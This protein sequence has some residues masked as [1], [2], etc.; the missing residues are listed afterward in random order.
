MLSF[1]FYQLIKH[2]EAFRKAQLEV[3]EVIGDGAIKVEHLS[4]LPYLN[5]VLRETLRVNA[6]IPAIAV[7][8]K[9]DDVIGGKYAVKKGEPVVCLLAKCHLD[10]LVYGEDASEFKPDRMLDENFEKLNKEFP[11]CWKPFGNGMRACIGRQFAWQE[12]LLVLAIL[13]QNFNFTFDDPSYQLSIKQNLTI[14]PLGFLM[15]ASPRQGMS[16]TAMEERLMSGSEPAKKKEAQRE[17]KA[18]TEQP[19]SRGKPMAI[20]YGSNTGTCEALAQRLANDAPSHGYHATVVDAMDSVNQSLSHDHPI[21]LLTASYEGQP[22]DNA[23]HFVTW[24]ESLNKESP[25]LNGVSYAVFGCGHHDWASTFHRIPKLVDQKM[26]E[27]GATRIAALGLADVARGDMFSDFDTWEADVFWPAMAEKYGAS[28]ATA[29]GAH[30]SIEVQVS[31]PRCSTLRQDVQEAL[32]VATK[33]LTAPGVPEK[34]HIEIQLPS[35]VTYRSGD[36]MAVL[37]LNSTDIVHRAMRRFKLAWDSHLTITSPGPTLLPTGHSIP[38]SDVFGAYVE[39]SQPATKR[40]LQALVALAKDEETQK[41]LEKLAGDDFET[42][43]SAKRVSLLDLLEH[44]PLLA[45]PMPN[46]LAMLPPM[47]VRQYSISS[48]PLWNP[49]HA[50][51]TF[52]ILDAPSFSDPEGKRYH[53][54]NS[55][56]MASLQEGDKLHVA[57]KPSHASFHLPSDG[58]H[59]P[60]ILV[61]A[62]TGLA[63]FRGFIQERA[64]QIATGRELADCVLWV[65]CREPEKDDIYHED[66]AK[67]EAM[68]AVTVRRA[69]SRKAAASDGC[70]YVQDR[71]WADRDRVQELWQKGARVF[72]CGS[73]EVGDAVR[74]I[75]LQISILNRRKRGD[76]DEAEMEKG[77]NE[78][79]DTIRNERYSTDVFA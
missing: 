61:A 65:G 56:Y 60:V 62:G 69:F 37:P 8:A 72:V 47:R 5:A 32:V 13:L 71:L 11:N 3:D 28:E 12:A 21:V 77:A 66:L 43:I 58:E 51:L 57:I 29:E 55:T 20:Y 45:L 2:P 25:T 70:K 63:P 59:T 44:F 1:A 36:Y 10:P 9:Q 33:T 19:K 48:S 78:W 52:S 64:A 73:R 68:G 22:P 50:T 67:W 76:T 15:R 7:T 34:K 30:P 74:K 6:T 42:E 79:F 38:A 35:H 14:K 26:A 18:G 75:A 17:R 4:K 54:V 16:A 53:G 46:F 40:D 23:A 27:Q 41:T 49:H 39:L 24:L 31:A